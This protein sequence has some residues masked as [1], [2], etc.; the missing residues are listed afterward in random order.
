MI[1]V[2]STTYRDRIVTD[3]NMTTHGRID[4]RLSH[5]SDL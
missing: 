3:N 1:D 5:D 2:S 4:S